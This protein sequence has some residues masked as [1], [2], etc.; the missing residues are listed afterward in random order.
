[1]PKTIPI[2]TEIDVAKNIELSDIMNCHEYPRALITTE[3]KNEIK[4][5]TNIPSIPPTSVMK[6]AS[7]KN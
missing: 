1:M 6:T 2:K 5:P 4:I 3:A 7:A